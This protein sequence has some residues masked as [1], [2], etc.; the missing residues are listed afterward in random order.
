MP[1]RLMGSIASVHHTLS[2][3]TSQ[4][5]DG[6]LFR[7]LSKIKEARWL[8]KVFNA[9]MHIEIQLSP[10]LNAIYLTYQTNFNSLN[11]QLQ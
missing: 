1:P 8:S 10:Q 3:S 9:A 11:K 5:T 2:I 4:T 7:V 6:V